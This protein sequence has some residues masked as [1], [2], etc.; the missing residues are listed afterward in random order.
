M[1]ISHGQ[2]MRVLVVVSSLL[3]LGCGQAPVPLDASGA[4]DP[5]ASA[6]A[7]PSTTLAATPPPTLRVLGTIDYFRESTRE[8]V[9]APDEVRAG[10]AFTVTVHT[11]RAGCDSA[12]DPVADTEVAFEGMV[13]TIRVYD[14]RTETAGVLCDSYGARFPHTAT[15]EFTT[16]GEGVLRVEGMRVGPETGGVPGVPTTVEHRIRVH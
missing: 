15:I 12:G 8:A 16:P 1:D 9:D 6:R 4:S 10:E 3:V 5:P 11:H 2:R 7:I 13:A 14:Q